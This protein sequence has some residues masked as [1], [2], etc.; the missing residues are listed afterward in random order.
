MPQA[1]A[2]ST[3]QGV[4]STHIV[5]NA[6]DLAALIQ[7]STIENIQDSGS[8]RARWRRAMKARLMRH[9]T[10]V[11]PMPATSVAGPSARPTARPPTP[12]N[13]GQGRR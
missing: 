5:R 10:E 8:R 2:T 9:V 6:A 3:V 4:P 13:A 11:G 1:Q 7:T 12:N